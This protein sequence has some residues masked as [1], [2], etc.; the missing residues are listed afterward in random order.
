MLNQR[1]TEASFKHPQEVVSWFGA[2]QAQDYS[3]AKWA[4]TL[5]SNNL[6]DNLL[7]Q[8]FAEGKI[9][10]THVLRPTWQFVT[11]ADIRWLLQLSSLRIHEQMRHWYLISGLDTDMF[12]KTDA[13]IAKVLK[14]GNQLTR[15]EIG[16][17]LKQSNIGVELNNLRLTFMMLHAEVEGIICSG[18]LRGKEHTYALLDERAPQNRHLT[19]DEALAELVKRYF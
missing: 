13:T 17:V 1:I 3:A 11:P 8:A 15:T 7:D 16:S 14:G 5:R 10:R 2:M 4:V 12:K 9:L 18:A 6:T 19:H